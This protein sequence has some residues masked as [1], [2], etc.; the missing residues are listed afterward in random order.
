M[1]SASR[2]VP[3]VTSAPPAGQRAATAPTRVRISSPVGELMLEAVDGALTRLAPDTADPAPDGDPAASRQNEEVLEE[4]AAQVRGYFRG[5]R[6]TFDLPLRLGGTAF[7]QRVWAALREIPYGQT[8][9]YGELAARIGAP[10]A[11]RAVGLANGRNPIPIIVPCHRVVA[12]DGTLGGYSGG[13]ERKRRLLDL[14][15]VS[16]GR[17]LL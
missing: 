14:E 2:C 16:A 4:A 1:P 13:L 9:S 6:R 11:S 15:Q 10:G 12:A 8:I 5:T 17:R 3:V 7:Q